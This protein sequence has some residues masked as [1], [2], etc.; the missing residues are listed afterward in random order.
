MSNGHVDPLHGL[1]AMPDLLLL[2]DIHAEGELLT[3]TDMPADKRPQL[4]VFGAGDDPEA[5][6]L[7]MRAGARDYLSLPL[8]KKEVFNVVTTIAGEARGTAD[9][10]AGSLH[11]LINGKGG[12]GASFLA[13]NIAHGL[14]S[15]SQTVTLV[16]LDLQFA[17]LCRYLDLSPQRDL[18]EAV[19]SVNEMDEISATA[20]T[21][22]HASGLRLLSCLPGGKLRLN[23]DILPEQLVSLL[24]IYRSFNDFVI[25]DLPRHIDLVSASVLENADRISVVTQQSFP[26]L[27]D[28]ARLLEILRGDLGIDRSK[29][30]VIVNR[31]DKSSQIPM[32]DIEKALKTENLVKIA[33]HYASTSESVNSGIPLIDVT[34]RS[35]VTKGLTEYCR[36]LAPAAAKKEGTG[37]LQ[38][39]FGRS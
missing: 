29:I 38:R 11:V 2:C 22:V 24:Q 12:S 9:S 28:T 21:S 36:S 18:V 25:V 15:H 17:G 1:E 10:S 5:I 30:T 23:A 32:A 13:A 31:F 37:A 14:V 39:L 19:Q 8:N 20:F 34:R 35:A 16:D 33:N 7:A 6:R 26:H 4:I 27:N 3:L